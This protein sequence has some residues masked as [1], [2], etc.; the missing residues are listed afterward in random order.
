[1]HISLLIGAEKP[2]APTAEETLAFSVFVIMAGFL[3]TV[4]NQIV[5]MRDESL[6]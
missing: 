3:L 5:A 6:A 1:V 4:A 2:V